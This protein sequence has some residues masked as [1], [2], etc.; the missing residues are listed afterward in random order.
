[1]LRS[2]EKNR[3][4][5]V[6]YDLSC[7]ERRICLASSA[8]K[9]LEV[10][11]SEVRKRVKIVSKMIETLLCF[12]DSAQVPLYLRPIYCIFSDV[13]ETLKGALD[14][15][16]NCGTK[17]LLNRIFTACSNLNQF[18]TLFHRLDASISDLEWLLTLYDPP[19][20]ATC[21]MSGRK[22]VKL[23][24]WCCI[25]TAQMGRKLEDR[26]HA[27]DCLGL[28]ASEKDEYKEII[29]EEGGVP[30]LQ[31]LLKETTS[32]SLP[33]VANALCLLAYGNKTREFIV[34]EMISTIVDRL[35]TR[36]PMTDR[37]QAADLVASIAEH[38][39]E[40]KECD[41]IREH[42]I[43]RLVTSLSPCRWQSEDDPSAK[44]QELQLKTSCS[45]ALLI[46]VRGSCRNCMALRETKG[47]LCLAK[48]V[49]TEQGELQY[50]CLMIIQEMTSLAE[51][52]ICF[53]HSWFKSTSPAANAVV[54]QLRRVIEEVDDTKLK[55]L[56]IKARIF[57]AKHSW[58]ISGLVTQLANADPQV[59]TE[60]AIALHK[61]VCQE[62]FVSFEH[63]KS[64]IKL[65]GQF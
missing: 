46:L 33:L 9:S 10:E 31:K 34:N 19:N 63:S 12:I 1:M 64:I 49:E 35:A 36:S 15:V 2:D 7:L 47:M 43:W 51:S 4:K 30:P 52:D 37:I 14:I 20:G 56:A 18:H 54:E 48:L 40:L 41:S 3:I 62:N 42:G 50:N 11:C 60:A 65:R 32:G 16:S 21:P 6:F 45:K 61:F 5:E 39:P 24:V 27:A 55:I 44:L 8:A 53:R 25:A 57:S 26:L 28:L 38:N 29:F 22:S 59:A 13:R 23:A 58:V 17:T